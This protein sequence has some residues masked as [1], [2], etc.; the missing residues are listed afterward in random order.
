MFRALTAGHDCTAAWRKL[1]ETLKNGA[2]AF[3]KH[4]IGS[5]GGT[6]HFDVYWNG[7]E[8]FWC[9]LPEPDANEDHYWCPYGID[10]P[11]STKTLPITVEINPPVQGINR[12][13]AGAFVQ[14]SD[15][16]I[17]LAHSGRLHCRKKG[18]ERSTFVLSYRHAN[19]QPVS[20]PDGLRKSMIIL[21]RV[22]GPEL[23]IQIGNFV[24]EVARFKERP[25]GET[26]PQHPEPAEP[27]LANRQEPGHNARPLR[28]LEPPPIESGLTELAPAI[29]R[30]IP[31]ITGPPEAKAKAVIALNRSLNQT[32]WQELRAEAEPLIKSLFQDIPADYEGKR[33]RAFLINALLTAFEQGIVI[34]D[35][36]GRP[37][38][39]GVQATHG[40]AS[41]VTGS[42][43]LLERTMTG[44]SRR[45]YSIPAL[46][47]L[48]IIR[49]Q[50]REGERQGGQA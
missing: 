21:G 36:Q 9:C 38:V 46:D 47:Q 18:I 10:D 29:M 14:E 50:P 48:R 41:D 3:R 5:P 7:D 40:R 13:L 24:R 33:T 6:Y 32:F 31:R 45:T 11:A 44:S 30:I 43:R 28:G 35:D 39:C 23:R 16:H 19:W 34:R 15:D 2:K 26:T 27:V 12:R 49:T 25:P 20:W 8:R 4:A 1:K 37:H 17:Y 22:D 42:F